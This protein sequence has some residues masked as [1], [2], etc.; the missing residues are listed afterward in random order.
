MSCR[1]TP[2]GSLATTFIQ[3]LYGLFDAQCTSLFH[4]ARRTAITP[5]NPALPGEFARALN[6]IEATI[7]VSDAWTPRLRER[8]LTR[9]QQ[10][11]AAGYPGDQVAQAF[12]HVQAAA[13]LVHVLRG[14]Y[15][16]EISTEYGWAEEDTRNEY[17]RIY[18]SF[19][20]A[21]THPTHATFNATVDG[22]PSDAAT[23]YTLGVI[24]HAARCSSC[25]Q[26]LGA[27]AHTCPPE[28]SRPLLS[29]VEP[30][31]GEASL[32]QFPDAAPERAGSEPDPADGWVGTVT[33]W[34]IDEFQ[35]AYD[36]ARARIAAG[37][38]RIPVL[39]STAPGEVTGGLGLRGTGNSFGIEI[40]L[41][42]PDDDYPYPAREHFARRLYDEGIVVTPFVQ[43]WHHV[44]DDRP[45][46]EYDETPS[47]WIC[48]FDRSV[49]ELDGER[50]VEI[51]SQI[52][53]DEPV[54]W[55]NIQ[56]IC[57]IAEE[58]G[59]RPTRRTGLHVN[60][61][62]SK[63]ATDD[64]AVHNSLLRLAGAYD[65]TL[66]RLAH[67]PHS[68]NRHRGRAYCGLANIPPAGYDQVATA[69]A[70]SNH[71]QAFNL[72]HLPADGQRHRRSSRVE[73][74]VW[75]STTELGRIQQAVNVS[76]GMVHLAIE[77]RK[78]GQPI[79]P[80]GTHRRAYGTQKLTGSR[81]DDSTAAFR[82]MVTLFDSI[83]LSSPA[84]REG[85]TAMF[86]ESR[87]H[88]QTY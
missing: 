76:L 12:V 27:T 50:G 24:A 61:G 68:G 56:R 84:H 34:S 72:G 17:E 57:Q 5:V 77:G 43:R 11:R 63:F 39:P 23:R 36:N 30:S 62:G 47:G 38:T 73:V 64:P 13:T 51:K 79:E 6:E 9:V 71:Y 4:A 21:R 2:A 67:N 65:D 74:R 19:P 70:Y 40:E 29:T 28:G 60:V 26:F 86:A 58:L 42:F 20:Q 37:D 14:A 59:A 52:L 22:M 35:D 25:G 55:Y 66:V 33:P 45:G 1:S 31:L 75:D 83:G 54:T 81:W 41:D 80:A 18:R 53:Y 16:R 49:D 78:P 32:S 8:A 87:W 15:L 82:R 46:G 44:G 48:E 3:R 85:L 10:A 88:E 7:R 69:R